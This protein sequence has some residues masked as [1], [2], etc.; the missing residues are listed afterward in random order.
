MHET[1]LERHVEG[2]ISGPLVALARLVV[3]RF[4]AA[5]G[6]DHRGLALAGGPATQEASD[7]AMAVSDAA[8]FE[9]V[10]VLACGLIVL[11]DATKAAL[12]A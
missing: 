7:G 12:D 11:A 4:V 10:L 2:E 5:L 3:R 9:A 8:T 6:V 1:R